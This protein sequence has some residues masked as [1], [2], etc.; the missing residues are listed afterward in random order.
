MFGYADWNVAVRDASGAS[1]IRA[2]VVT[3]R[4]FT[5]LGVQ[6]LLGRVVT[7]ADALGHSASRPLVLSYA[8]W[9][10]H[11]NE[12][13]AARTIVD[14]AFTVVGVLPHRFNGIA[15]ESTP[16]DRL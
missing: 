4:F 11:R 3:G 6:P 15:V 10:G 9:Q 7:E 16:D 2:Q 14:R 1:R 13:G 8:Y 12:L 5:A